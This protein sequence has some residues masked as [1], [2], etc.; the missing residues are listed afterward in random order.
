MRAKRKRNY[1]MRGSFKVMCYQPL[2]KAIGNMMER[3]PLL[4]PERELLIEVASAVE[5]WEKRYYF[6]VPARPEGEKK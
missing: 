6:I 1:R 5:R 3:D 2:L 4:G